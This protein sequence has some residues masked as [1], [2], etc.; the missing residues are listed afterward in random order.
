MNK[1]QSPEQVSSYMVET[2]QNYLFGK[3]PEK[4]PKFDEGESGRKNSNAGQLVDKR[5]HPWDKALDNT[6]F[7]I[8]CLRPV[9]FLPGS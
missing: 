6:M 8:R 3:D 2:V 9:L 5:K 1:E 4:P 7:Y